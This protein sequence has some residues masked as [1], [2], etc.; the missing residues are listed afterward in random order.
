MNALRLT[1]TGRVVKDDDPDAG[2]SFLAA[3]PD[4]A[5]YSGF[6][7]FAFHRFNIAAGHLVAGFGR[8]VTLRPDELLVR[9]LQD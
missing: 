4:A 8:I 6:A 1:L 7:D 5:R 2:S 3:H 9:C